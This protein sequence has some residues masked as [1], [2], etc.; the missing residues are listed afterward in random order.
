MAEKVKTQAGGGMADEIRWIELNLIDIPARGRG[1]DPDKV[2][3][4]AQDMARN[5]QL[6]DIVVT[7]GGDGRFEVVAGRGRYLAAKQLNWEKV[8]ALVK[9]NLSELDKLLIMI[10]ENDEREDVTPIDRGLSYIWAMEAG[11]MSQE[12]LAAKLGKTQGY[13]SQY[14][15]AAQLPE[16][17]RKI[18]NRLIIGITHINQ[19]VRLPTPE[20]QLALAEKC[21]K[22]ELSVKQLE[23]IVKKTLSA[24]SVPAGESEA[25]KQGESAGTALKSAAAKLPPGF[26]MAMAGKGVHISGTFPANV[27]LPELVKGIEDSFQQWKSRPET[28]KAAKPGRQSAKKP[29]KAPADT[30]APALPDGAPRIPDKAQSLDELRKIAKAMATGGGAAAFEA[31]THI[32]PGFSTTQL[33]ANIGA[34]KQKLAE[35]GLSAEE[36]SRLK[37]G[38][39]KA[40]AVVEQLSKVK[41][42]PNSS[43]SA[44]SDPGPKDQIESSNS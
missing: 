18:I 16:P 44:P 19:I 15:S 35:P 29:A 37:A 17:V 7:P 39:Q 38:I 42:P 12:A 9:D 43:A 20:A 24:S 14:V 30:L 25:G 31:M 27:T 41:Q 11:N 4:L 33:E 6:Q 26:R 21:Q 40:Q 10:S 13:I 23:I 22:D 1:H 36:A 28:P 2:T 5:G 32:M 34:M 3:E 8:Q